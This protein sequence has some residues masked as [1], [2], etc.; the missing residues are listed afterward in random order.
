M[1]ASWCI[2]AGPLCPLALFL[3]QVAGEGGAQVPG[4]AA[5]CTRECEDFLPTLALSPTGVQGRDGGGE[6]L[7]CDLTQ[8]HKNWSFLERAERGCAG[9]PVAQ[10][11]REGREDVAGTLSPGLAAIRHQLC[12]LTAGTETSLLFTVPTHLL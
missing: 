2:H 12:C 3:L 5:R 6:G 11:C 4:G 8:G 10:G 9:L 7:S 1:R